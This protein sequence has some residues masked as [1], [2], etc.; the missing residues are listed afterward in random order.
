ME[1]TPHTPKPKLTPKEV[2][3]AACRCACTVAFWKTVFDCLLDT[4]ENAMDPDGVELHVKPFEDVMLAAVWEP[5]I[6]LTVFSHYEGQ[7]TDDFSLQ[8]YLDTT[9]LAWLVEVAARHG[10]RHEPNTQPAA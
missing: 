7:E 2:K 9:Q 10:I 4:R 1:P 3:A 6:G 5:G 8:S